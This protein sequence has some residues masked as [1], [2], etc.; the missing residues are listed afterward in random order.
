[1]GP[2]L[3]PANSSVATLSS[4]CAGLPANYYAY[5]QLSDDGLDDAEG[6][7]VNNTLHFAY[8]VAFSLVDRAKGLS[9]GSGYREQIDGFSCTAPGTRSDCRMRS[10]EAACVRPHG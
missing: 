3:A 6:T 5:D 10:D 2:S 1:M 7:Q 9:C 8:F 4:G